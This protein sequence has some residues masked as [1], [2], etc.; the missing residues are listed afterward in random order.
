MTFSG[1]V[2]LVEE[3]RGVEGWV[4]AGKPC[5]TEEAAVR[6]LAAMRRRRRDLHFQVGLYERVE[7]PALP[8]DAT[9]R[10]LRTAEATG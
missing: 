1:Y 7:R 10:D 8:A 2:Y 6:R 9:V 5:L 4:P 3:Y